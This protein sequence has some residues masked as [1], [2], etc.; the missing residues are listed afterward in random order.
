MSAILRVWDGTSWVTVASGG[1]VTPVT[2]QQILDAI[3]RH[4]I[5]PQGV[6]FKEGYGLNWDEYA[7]GVLPFEGRNRLVMAT[8]DPASGDPVGMAP[9]ATTDDLKGSLTQAVADGLYAAKTH[10]HEAVDVVGLVEFSNLM[11]TTVNELGQQLAAVTDELATFL[12]EP[13]ADPLY[14]PVISANQPV[15]AKVGQIWLEPVT[16]AAAAG[17]RAEVES[18]TRA[19]VDQLLASRPTVADTMEI[20]KRLLTGGAEPP[21]DI[22]WTPC[23]KI[24]GSGLVEARLYNGMIQ[25]RGSVTITTTN[26]TDVVSL[27]AN[28]PKPKQTYDSVVHGGETG[29]AERLVI[30]S[31]RANGIVSINPLSLKITSTQMYP[32]TAPVV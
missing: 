23:T 31:I 25:L 27:P 17:A 9:I 14:L 19:E 8:I 29:V 12:T 2:D 24:A 22:D 1:T 10:T 15:A 13:K 16:A 6:I 4:G 18:Y 21:P 11:E 7:V 26:W 28:F 32:A 5:E 30:V 3:G 20:V